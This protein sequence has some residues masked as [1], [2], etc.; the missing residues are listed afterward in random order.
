MFYRFFAFQ[1]D[2]IRLITFYWYTN[3]QQAP[4]NQRDHFN[5]GSIFRRIHR[6]IGDELP[7]FSQKT[8]QIPSSQFYDRWELV[9]LIFGS[10]I[11]VNERD[12]TWSGIFFPLTSLMLPKSRPMYVLE[13]LSIS[14][15]WL[16]AFTATETAFHSHHTSNLGTF[17]LPN[18]S[19]RLAVL[20]C[21]SCIQEP[22]FFWDLPSGGHS[23][24]FHNARLGIDAND[25][26]SSRLSR[27]FFDALKEFTTPGIIRK[28]HLSLD[29]LTLKITSQ[30][31]ARY[32]CKE[33]N[34]VKKPLNPQ[35]KL[36]GRQAESRNLHV[37][38]EAEEEFA[39]LKKLQKSDLTDIVA[40]VC[41]S[42]GVARLRQLRTKSDAM[43]WLK[44]HWEISKGVIR[45]WHEMQIDIQRERSRNMQGLL[46]RHA[47]IH[48]GAN[49]F[50]NI[51]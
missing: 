24:H 23:L 31:K 33:K 3:T 30:V 38:R 43:D 36:Q 14:I 49:M 22:Y 1:Y 34:S 7:E 46:E 42:A 12:S 13:T 8:C 20:H 17:P 28:K 18:L 32:L 11:S 29:Q 6:H 35:N 26:V 25:P 51:M 4:E 5:P 9:F 47:Q 48:H 10:C 2:R 44:E 16:R 40:E 45:L 37:A 50:W 15:L 27:S 41:R 19:G 21:P 39:C